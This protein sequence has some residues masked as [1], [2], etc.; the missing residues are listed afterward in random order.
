M[1]KIGCVRVC[2]RPTFRLIVH[3]AGSAVCKITGLRTAC[4][5]CMRASIACIIHVRAKYCVQDTACKIYTACKVY[6]R[7]ACQRVGTKPSIIG[8]M[9]ALGCLTKIIFYL[10]KDTILV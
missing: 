2:T 7:T 5:V 1:Q 8:C 10:P 6:L 4:K 9:F 3:T